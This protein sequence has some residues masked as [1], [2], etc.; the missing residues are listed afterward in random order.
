MT[1]GY[2]FPLSQPGIRL[3]AQIYPRNSANL[4]VVHTSTTS[5][6][7]KYIQTS[8]KQLRSHRYAIQQSVLAKNISRIQCCKNL[9]NYK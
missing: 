1:L 7:E 4:H 3:T 5:T 2:V 8:A 6:T 9:L